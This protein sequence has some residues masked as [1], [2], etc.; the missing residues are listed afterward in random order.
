MNKSCWL[1]FEHKRL[2]ENPAENV[3]WKDSFAPILCVCKSWGFAFLHI[4]CVPFTH[5]PWHFNHRP[6]SDFITAPWLLSS[7]LIRSQLFATESLALPLCSI[8]ISFF[9]YWNSNLV[10]KD[11]VIWLQATVYTQCPSTFFPLSILCSSNTWLFHVHWTSSPS[12]MPLRMRF[13]FPWDVL[14]I[15]QSQFSL[16]LQA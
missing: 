1:I 13:L 11:F 10:V 16:F 6:R 14:F 15:L 12:F 3:G 9:S 8:T 5:F 7:S 4:T 2:L